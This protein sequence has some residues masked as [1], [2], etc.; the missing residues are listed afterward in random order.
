MADTMQLAIFIRGVNWKFYIT[1][2]ITALS[3]MKELV[4]PLELSE[5]S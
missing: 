2:E 1:E 4:T 3:I 5:Q